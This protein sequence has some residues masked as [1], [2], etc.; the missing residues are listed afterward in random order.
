MRQVAKGAAKS[1]KTV[2]RIERAAVRAEARAAETEASQ[3]IQKKPNCIGK[4]FV[5]GTLVAT[6]D[7][8]RPI[9]ELAIGDKD[10]GAQSRDRA[11]GAGRG[12]AALR[13]RSPETW[14]LTLEGGG[15][16]IET[17]A[18]HPFFIEGR[19]FVAA[20]QPRSATACKPRKG[21]G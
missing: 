16:Q 20:D 8:E 5:A 18:E 15:P 2:G 7:G 6:E 12:G 11:Q 3:L 1:G 17:T 14:V 19:G 21:N 10:L 9:E 13:P 4:C